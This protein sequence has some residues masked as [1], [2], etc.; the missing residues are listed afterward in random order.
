[1]VTSGQGAHPGPR[2][3]GWPERGATVAAACILSAQGTYTVK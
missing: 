1:M 2:Q 3:Y